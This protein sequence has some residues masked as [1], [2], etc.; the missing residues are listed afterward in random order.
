[1]QQLDAS[2]GDA[3]ASLNSFAASAAS[4][5]YHLLC[6]PDDVEFHSSDSISP[7]DYGDVKVT[8]LITLQLA[9]ASCCCLL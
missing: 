1:M 4:L 6:T 8:P 3:L 5:N 2:D 9:V 7:N